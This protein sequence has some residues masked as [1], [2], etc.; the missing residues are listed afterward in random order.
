MTKNVLNV[1]CQ[2]LWI[3]EQQHTHRPYNDN[4]INTLVDDKLPKYI[5]PSHQIMYSR[6][7]RYFELVICV[8]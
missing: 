8:F 4:T 6:A 3:G 7:M 5:P 2:I 1:L